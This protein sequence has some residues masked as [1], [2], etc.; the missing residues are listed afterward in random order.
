V[1][2]H[3]VTFKLNDPSPAHAE[4]C[5]AMLESL[6]GKVPTLRTMTVGI[7]VV[8]SPRAHTLAL[9]AT[10]DDLEG[11]E[12]YQVHPDHQEVAGYL[13]ANSEVIASV[14]FER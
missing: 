11:L 14:D 5:K 12:A 6:V 13:R 2:T 1:I 3:I 9:I 10:Y 8:D 7:N 4:R